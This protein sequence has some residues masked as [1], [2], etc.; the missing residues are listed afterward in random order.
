MGRP[1][2]GPPRP[3]SRRGSAVVH[4]SSDWLLP[5]GVVTT[6]FSI[7]CLSAARKRLS[8]PPFRSPLPPTQPAD[9][10]VGSRAG[11]QELP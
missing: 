8:P 10:H 9:P 6:F 2:A 5:P 7:K 11:G 1:M 4:T 3:L